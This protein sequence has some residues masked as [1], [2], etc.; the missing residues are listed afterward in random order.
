MGCRRFWWLLLILAL[1]AHAADKP[2]ILLLLA[3]DMGYNDLAT[4]NGND[5]PTP[6]LDRLANE[7]IR[8]TRFYADATCQ[9][10]RAA[11]LSGRYPARSGF[12]PVGRGLPPEWT[13]LPEALK[14][15]GYRTHHVGK[16]HLG[17]APRQAWP[18]FQGFDSSFG[19]L[20]QWMLSGPVS[21]GNW[22][23][24]KPTYE[25]P[26][27][28]RGLD[29]SQ[30]YEGHLEDLLTAETVKLIREA[31]RAEPWFIY[32]AFYAPH[33]P[34][35][36]AQRY[37]E[38]YP[39][40]PEGIYRAVIHQLDD[41]VAA[42]L[43][44]LEDS[45][46]ADNTIVVFASD[47]GGPN[48]VRD[49]NA[50]F[51]GKKGEY[52]E[53]GL[54]TFM[55]WRWPDRAVVGV[56]ESVTSIMDIYPSLLHAIGGDMPEDLD[57]V[58][59]FDANRK[60]DVPGRTLYWEN[61]ALLPAHRAVLS[62]DGQWL[63]MNYGYGLGLYSSSPYEGAHNQWWRVP[64]WYS[65]ESQYRLWSKQ[66]SNIDLTIM[67]DDVTG[68]GKVEGNILQRAPG[69]SGFTFGLGVTVAAGEGWQVLAEQ[70][71][72]WRLEY[73]PQEGFR[74]TVN[75]LPLASTQRLPVGKCVPVMLS[76]YWF[77]PSLLW[78]GEPDS[79]VELLVDGELIAETP[80]KYSDIA[81]ELFEQPTWIG[82]AADGS[83]SFQGRLGVPRFLNAVLAGGWVSD[84]Q[85]FVDS[86]CVP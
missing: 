27:L 76:G 50:P 57:G 55:L 3:D 37:R 32:H 6:T 45:G 18:R 36:P 8:F 54:H 41:S 66:A 29:D 23:L 74:G 48:F 39:D 62:V 10:A 52:L 22:T 59:M 24:S 43:Q 73:H 85:A 64:D 60:P 70:T 69:L 67:R 78:G 25:N 13:I 72:V 84:R 9:P 46:Q 44:A 79:W 86:L 65:L 61:G 53:G 71:G 75:G 83:Q 15:Q 4:N 17:H 11:L 7:S 1:P 12:R 30:Q 21:E 14:A 81:A 51:V 16:W 26:W 80:G 5:M 35:E 20:N 68:H 19:F 63:Y 42:I 38:R 77:L 49:N 34:N 47:N 58:V 40:T 31:D 28:N 56:D 82:R 33:T 2:N